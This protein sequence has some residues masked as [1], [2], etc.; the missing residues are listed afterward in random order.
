MQ[1]SSSSCSGVA[2]RRSP[3]RPP[4]PRGRGTALITRATG[5]A[6]TTSSSID[7]LSIALRGLSPAITAPA[8][9]PGYSAGT[10][11]SRPRRRGEHRRRTRWRAASSA[12]IFGAPVTAAY[13]KNIVPSTPVRLRRRPRDRDGASRRVLP[14]RTTYN[15]A[16]GYPSAAYPAPIARPTA[17]TARV[18]TAAGTYG[19]GYGYDYGSPLVRPRG[20]LRLWLRLLLRVR[21]RLRLRRRLPLQVSGTA[22]AVSTRSD[23]PLRRQSYGPGGMHP[24]FR[25]LA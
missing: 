9:A 6:R 5:I 20:R 25:D 21:L 18:I 13:G 4:L 16:Y 14:T 23:Q 3:C 22:T 2:R 15:C 7:G 17:I 1:D 19:Y 10:P 12:E 8:V 11:V 24:G